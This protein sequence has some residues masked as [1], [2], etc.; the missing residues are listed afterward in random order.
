MG[1]YTANKKAA[2]KKQRTSSNQQ[3]NKISRKN[4]KKIKTLQDL[5]E[6]GLHDIYSVEI[7]LLEAMPLIAKA[8]Y[9]EDL[10]NAIEF[11]LEQTQRQVERLEKVFSRLNVTKNESHVCEAMKGLIRESKD[12]IENYEESPV[13]DSAIIIAA[14]KIEHYEIACYG[15]LCELSDVLGYWNIHDTLGRSLNEEEVTDH[16]LSNLALLVN[17]E[18]CELSDEINKYDEESN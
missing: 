6:D 7:Q 11:H 9:N 5:L 18:A 13:R 10:Q 4:P 8:A 15:S 2:L 12:I 17:D 16:D 1:T 14:Q 3:Q